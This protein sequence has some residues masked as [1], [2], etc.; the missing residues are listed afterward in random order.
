MKKIVRLLPVV[1]FAMLLG[2]ASCGSKSKS[3]AAD[4]DND[5]MME[6]SSF[7]SFDDEDGDIDMIEESSVEASPSASSSGSGV[8]IDAIESD[9]RGIVRDAQEEAMGIVRDAQRE[10][11]QTLRDAGVNSHVIKQ[12]AKEY[13]K[14]L[15]EME[16]ELDN[17]DF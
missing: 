5:D 15:D 11:E 4:E 14:A 7:T 9:A 6:E 2:L 8:D 16:K 13:N 3:E 12:A 10:A 17:L 1:G